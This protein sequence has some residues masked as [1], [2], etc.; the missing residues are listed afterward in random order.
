VRTGSFRLR[1]RAHNH[2]RFDELAQ[3]YSLQPISVI[4][5]ALE[6]VLAAAGGQRDATAFLRTGFFGDLVN[7]REFV[8]TFQLHLDKLHSHGAR[9]AVRDA[10]STSH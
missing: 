10:N 7:D 2:R 5:R 4:D 1:E 9:A 6:T 3:R 8:T